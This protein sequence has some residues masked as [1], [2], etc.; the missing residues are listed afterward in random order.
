MIYLV[1]T[2]DSLFPSTIYSRLSSEEAVK[3]VESFDVIQLDSETLGR[4]PHLVPILTLQLGNDAQQCRIVIDATTID[5]TIFKHALENKLCVGHNLKFDLQFLYKHKIIPTHVFDTM[6]V[7]QLLHLGYNNKFFRYNLHDTAARYI[8]GLDID[9]SVRGEIIWR[10]LDE[11]TIQY[12]ATDV[13]YLEKLM[14]LEEEAC[15]KANCVQG[16]RLENEFVPVIAYLEWCGIKLDVDKWKQKMQSDADNAKTAEE[17]LNN[18]IKTAAKSDKFFQKYIDPQLDLFDPEPKILLNWSSAQQL[19]PI[20]QHLGFDTKVQDKE[21]GMLK[22]SISDKVIAKQK[23]INDE[24]LK[25]FFGKGNPDD[26]D[27]YA[28]YQGA[29]KVVST[30]GQSYLNAINPY[31]GRIHTNFKQL[32][33]ASGRMACGS[34]QKNTDLSKVNHCEAGYPQLQNL[35]A[36]EATRG[37]FVPEK[38]NL[39]CSCDYSALESRLGADIYNEQEMLNEYLYGSQDIHSL[40]AKICFPHE[41]QGIDVKDI[42]KLRP[43]LRKKAKGPEFKRTPYIEIYM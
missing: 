21:T 17:A 4:D 43:D 28:G 1:T 22:D 40:T 18:W 33:A 27:Y 16:M 2:Q 10:G 32:G 29:T 38:G 19:I 26:E 7:E 23:G 12:A 15:K 8:P 3:K 31:T 41:L 11:R 25:L 35:P 6:V 5:I 39:M 34:K 36:D 13:V 24:L 9:K 30:Y 42:K 37:A 20:F 14:H